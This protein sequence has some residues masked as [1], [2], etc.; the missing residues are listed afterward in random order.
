MATEER[1]GGAAGKN[2]GLESNFTI[3]SLLCTSKPAASYNF[4]FKGFSLN[5]GLG[6]I[7]F[8]AYR[9]IKFIYVQ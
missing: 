3:S 2:G 4:F 6:Y 8:L 5:P 9:L 7:F 1:E